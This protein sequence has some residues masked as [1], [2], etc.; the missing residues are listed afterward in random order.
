MANQ[1]FK[2]DIRIKNKR[3]SFEY[4]LMDRFVAGIQ[5]RGTEIKSLREGKAQINESFIQVKDGEVFAV[6]MYIEE[7]TQGTYS[8]HVP[9]RERK[10]LLQKREIKKIEKNLTTKG[11]TAVPLQLFINEN[12]LAKLEFALAQ[13]KKLYDK[14]E[15]LK[16]KDVKRQL[17][18]GSI[19]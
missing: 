14:R 12:G 8:N 7:Y 6:N 18:R 16:K 2:N 15:D 10:L 9:R 4:Q 1:R 11:L 13:G 5:L 3:A 17:D 19:D